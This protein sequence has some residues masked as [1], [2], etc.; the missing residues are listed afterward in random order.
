MAQDLGYSIDEKTGYSWTS[1]RNLKCEIATPHEF[2]PSS[3]SSSL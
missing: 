2:G 1:V 3:L